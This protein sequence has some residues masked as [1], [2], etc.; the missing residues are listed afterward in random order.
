MKSAVATAPTKISRTNSEA[1]RKVESAAR[2]TLRNLKIVPYMTTV[3]TDSRFYEPITDGIFRFVPFR[4]VQEDISGMHG[5]N[6]RLKLE[7]L[8]EGITFFMNLIEKN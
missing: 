5:T 1:Y 2:N 8:M 7:S 4:S 3:T 6:E